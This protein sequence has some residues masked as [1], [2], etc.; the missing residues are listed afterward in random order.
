MKALSCAEGNANAD[1]ALNAEPLHFSP[2]VLAMALHKDLRTCVQGAPLA[3]WMCGVLVFKVLT[4]CPFPFSVPK[5]ELLGGC[6]DIMSEMQNTF[7]MMVSLRWHFGVCCWL[8]YV[9]ELRYHL[10]LQCI[11]YGCTSA[12]FRWC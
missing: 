1:D 3:S 12:A 10:D 11:W 4:H 8:S 6:R 9:W 5:Q 2:E 7:N